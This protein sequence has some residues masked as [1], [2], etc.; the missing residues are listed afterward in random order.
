MPEVSLRSPSLASLLDWRPLSLAIAGDAAGYTA[1]YTAGG[2]WPIGFLR[3]L[4][5]LLAINNGLTFFASL[6]VAFAL[7]PSSCGRLLL[8]S[9]A[10]ACGRLPSPAFLRPPVTWLLFHEN[11]GRELARFDQ[12]KSIFL[13]YPIAF[14]L[15]LFHLSVLIT[16]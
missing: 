10:V 1:G 2:R 8:R 5:S 16:P 12:S 11:S 7:A 9:P 6:L 15:T 13:F 14:I 4:A 3:P